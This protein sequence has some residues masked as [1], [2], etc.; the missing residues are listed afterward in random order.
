MELWREISQNKMF[1]VSNKGNI[2]NKATKILLRKIISDKYEE[3]YVPNLSEFYVHRIVAIEFVENA[4]NYKIVRHKNG[5]KLDNRAEN[6]E[7]TSV[8]ESISKY[9][10]ENGHWKKYSCEVHVDNEII[11]EESIKNMAERLE[12]EYNIK[13]FKNWVKKEVP[14][15]YKSRIKLIKIKDEIIFTQKSLYL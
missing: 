12:K 5:N 6:L 3:V 10:E 8:K 2:R 13:R 4:N 7:W 14:N 15:K 1:E 9:I 11:Q